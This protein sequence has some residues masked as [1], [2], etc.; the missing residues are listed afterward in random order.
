MRLKNL[1]AVLHTN[2]F[3]Q[4]KEKKTETGNKWEKRKYYKNSYNKAVRKSKNQNNK[5]NSKSKDKTKK[6]INE[7]R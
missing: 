7:R 1:S 4:P 2:N 3:H 5:T 6:K